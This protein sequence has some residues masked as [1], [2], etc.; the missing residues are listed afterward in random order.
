VFSPCYYGLTIK[1][2]AYADLNGGK[3][4]CLTAA[5]AAALASSLKKS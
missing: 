5:Q 2:G 4:K 1:G 3:P